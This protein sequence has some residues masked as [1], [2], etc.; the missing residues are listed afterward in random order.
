VAEI[1]LL[2]GAIATLQCDRHDIADGGDHNVVV[3]HV[4]GVQNAAHDSAQPLVFYAGAYRSLGEPPAPAPG[5][6]R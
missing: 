2:E 4:T 3:G 1:P 5:P 6:D